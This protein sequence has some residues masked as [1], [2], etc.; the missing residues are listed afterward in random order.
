MVIPLF[1]QYTACQAA[2]AV[3]GGNAFVAHA[4]DD[5]AEGVFTDIAACSGAA[6]K[7]EIAMPRDSVQF[8]QKFHCPI[9][10]RYKV[11]AGAFHA[12]GRYQPLFLFK[13]ELAPLCAA[14][15]F[16]AHKNQHQQQNADAVLWLGIGQQQTA[17]E[18]GQF[19]ARQGRHMCGIGFFQVACQRGGGVAVNDFQHGGIVAD[20]VYPLADFLRRFHHTTRGHAV[21]HGL[22][23]PYP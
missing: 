13:V 20:A 18:L 2:E 14:Q 12:L 7:Q 21:N 6:G 1:V 16:V 10:K 8:G 3:R 15:F 9:G 5:F 17:V 22:N 19:F 4:V 23:I 11:G